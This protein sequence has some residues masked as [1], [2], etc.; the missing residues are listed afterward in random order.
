MSLRDGFHSFGK[1]RV[2]V[3]RFVIV[4]SSEATAMKVLWKSPE[5]L[6][7]ASEVHRTLEGRL[8]PKA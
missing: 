3:R 8:D 6:K 5:Q 2:C 1:I 7:V 4:L